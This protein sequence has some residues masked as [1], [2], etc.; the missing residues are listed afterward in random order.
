M[1]A[2]MWYQG[3]DNYQR[4]PVKV[5]DYIDGV[6]CFLWRVMI[7]FWD[8]FFYRLR[9][10]KVLGNSNQSKVVEIEFAIE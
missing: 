1:V 5:C 2:W 7:E 10:M 3:G 8:W 4:I 9:I 6:L